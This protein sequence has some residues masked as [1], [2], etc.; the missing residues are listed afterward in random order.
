MMG[1]TRRTAIQVG[2]LTVGLGASWSAM[3]QAAAGFCKLDLAYAPLA[4]PVPTLATLSVGILTAAVGVVAW[5]KAKPGSGKALSVAV[6]A[7][8]AAMTMQGG[9]GLMREVQAAA[10]YAFSN[11]QGGTV[12][13]T[14]IPYA[15]PAPLLTISN[16][17]SVPLKIVRNGNAADTGSCAVGAQLAPGASCTATPIC[18]QTISMVN[19]PVLQCDYELPERAEPKASYRLSKDAESFGLSVYDVTVTTKAVFSPVEPVPVNGVV[20]SSWPHT[21]PL[22]KAEPPYYLDN[23]DDLGIVETT[24]TYTAPSGYGFGTSLSPSLTWTNT[25][26]C[27][28][29]FDG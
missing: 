9:Q 6:L 1:N 17:T 2:T 18:L 8:A 23:M 24:I 4:S 20:T 27:G 11:A 15:S 3:A 16:T 19:E 29:S 10:P 12:S 7:A 14:S 25:Q 13:D 5:A 21:V 22:F 26:Q 28:I